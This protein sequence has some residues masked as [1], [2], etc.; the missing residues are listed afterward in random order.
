MANM[1]DESLAK[2]IKGLFSALPL[3]K[4]SANQVFDLAS[5]LLMLLLL[6]VGAFM[7]FGPGSERLKVILVFACLFLMAWS[8]KSNS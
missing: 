5:D 2:V 4:L 7:N 3:K 6:I 8:W 1:N